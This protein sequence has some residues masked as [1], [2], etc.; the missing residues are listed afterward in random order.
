MSKEWKEIY[1]LWE[2]IKEEWYT[3]VERAIE[4]KE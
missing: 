2:N 3:E 1:K 4:K